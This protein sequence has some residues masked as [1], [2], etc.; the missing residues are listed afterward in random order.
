MRERGLDREGRGETDEREGR[1]GRVGKRRSIG[2]RRGEIGKGGKRAEG[3]EET[4]EG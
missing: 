1:E 4:K 2:D 3:R